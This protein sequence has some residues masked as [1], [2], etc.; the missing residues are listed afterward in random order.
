M[1]R[2]E[3]LERW[4]QET[5]GIIAEYTQ[6]IQDADD[7][8]QRRRAE[9]T[10]EE[11]RGLLRGYLDEYIR[12]CQV[13]NKA[14]PREIREIQAG[15]Q[16]PATPPDAPPQHTRPQP[17]SLSLQFSRTESGLQVRYTSD[18][19]GEDRE[20]VTLPQALP[21]PRELRQA[22]AR[23]ALGQS[24]YRSL[25]GGKIGAA[26]QAV[27]NQAIQQ[28]TTAALQLRFDEDAVEEARWPW[29][30]CHDGR[31]YLLL[32]E[33]DL[34]RYITFPR[35]VVPVT[36]EPPLQVVL[37]SA[38]PSAP[39]LEPLNVQ[40]AET[41]LQGLANIQAH[42]VSPP[43]YQA[44]TRRL[45]TYQRPV[46]VF[47]FEGHGYMEGGR[48]SLCFETAEGE[49]HLVSTEALGAALSRKQ[50]ALAIINACHSAQVG[51]ET[52]FGSVAPALILAGVP[53]VIGMQDRIK[54]RVI[55]DFLQALYEN[56]SHCIPITAALADARVALYESGEWYKP[57][58][59]LRST[60]EQGRIFE[61]CR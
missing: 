8:K 43:T 48:V 28:H 34:T 38:R 40:M 25:F 33:V 17:L 56:I 30:L 44:L 24:L 26:L 55:P 1:S 54:D 46:H 13:L 4:I 53:A 36:V 16:I 58:L 29:E 7:P 32:G 27:R 3:D 11:Q 22:D 12:I 2:R 51:G 10:I 21:S 6:Q 52:L 45:R 20:N 9:R 15:L 39:F 60:D 5:T 57:V 42:P 18:L 14:V 61:G 47:D 31:Q 19:M 23:Q 37:V 59:Y 35:A 41:A 50:I 49:L